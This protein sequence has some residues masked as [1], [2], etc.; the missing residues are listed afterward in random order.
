MPSDVRSGGSSFGGYKGE[1]SAPA[2]KASTIRG[3]FISDESSGVRFGLSERRDMD[4]E[5]LGNL[6]YNNTPNPVNGNVRQVPKPYVSMS[7]TEKGHTF[8]IC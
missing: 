3:S 4:S 7:Y 2:H 6:S 1:Y 8:K 5:N